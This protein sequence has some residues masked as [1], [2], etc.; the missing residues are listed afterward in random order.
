MPHTTSFDNDSSLFFYFNYGLFFLTSRL[1]FLDANFKCTRWWP[2]TK[3]ICIWSYKQWTPLDSF[4]IF[5]RLNKMP[6]NM[7]PTIYYCNS[8]WR[9]LWKHPKNE[10]KRCGTL[11][12]HRHQIWLWIQFFHQPAN[13]SYLFV[14][15]VNTGWERK[16]HLRTHANYVKGGA[17]NGKQRA[18]SVESTKTKSAC[19][20][21]PNVLDPISGKRKGESATKREREKGSLTLLIIIHMMRERE[22]CRNGFY[23]WRARAT[24]AITWCA[25]ILCVSSVYIPHAP[26]CVQNTRAQESGRT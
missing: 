18:H 11:C 6:L 16:K 23:F 19:I 8:K 4:L 14:Y 22:F 17:H 9:F 7:T 26:H 1:C 20:Y 25:P 2:Q 10:P 5:S 3:Q 24:H 15:T 13:T 12:L 21:A